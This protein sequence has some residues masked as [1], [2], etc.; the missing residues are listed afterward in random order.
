MSNST[1]VSVFY[2]PKDRLRLTTGDRS[3]PTVKPVWVAPL[4]HP[5]KYLSFLDAK[6]KEILLIPDLDSLDPASQEAVKEELNRRYLTAQ[7]L[8][9]VHVKG[10]WGITYWTVETARGQRD[11]VTQSL[12]ENVQWLSS[13]QILMTDVDGNKFEI[14]DIEAMDPVSRELILKIL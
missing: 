1:E 12:Q 10:E 8:R 11:F 3:Y 2:A 6:D 13:V 5:D 14:K 7:I 4:S 9:V